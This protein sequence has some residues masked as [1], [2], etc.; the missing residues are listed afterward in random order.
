MV[1]AVFLYGNCLLHCLLRYWREYWKKIIHCLQ[2][3]QLN[4]LLVVIYHLAKRNASTPRSILR[5][6]GQ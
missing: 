6:S 3:A 5:V 4:L 2:E 1:M